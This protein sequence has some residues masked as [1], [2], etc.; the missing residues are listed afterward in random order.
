[1]IDG[2]A[3]LTMKKIERRHERAGEQHRE[4][5]PAA[6]IELVFLDRHHRVPPDYG[7]ISLHIR[8]RSVPNLTCF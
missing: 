6:R 3:T 4:R 1:V 2:M 8:E 7:H 5:R